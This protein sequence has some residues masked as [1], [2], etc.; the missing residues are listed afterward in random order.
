MFKQECCSENQQ[1][2]RFGGRVLSGVVK[3]A[4]GKTAAFGEKKNIG[5]VLH[6]SP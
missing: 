1:H 4:L 6:G 5:G 3:G 2:C